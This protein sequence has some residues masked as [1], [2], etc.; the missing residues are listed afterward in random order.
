MMP[1]TSGAF[2]YLEFVVQSCVT[3]AASRVSSRRQHAGGS[4]QNARAPLS[5]YSYE[6]TMPA[7]E[8]RGGHSPF[9]F[10]LDFG[11]RKRAF[12]SGNDQF[13]LAA[14]NFSGLAI[15]IDN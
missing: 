3:L 7:Q 6:R 13:F 11:E 4:G 12:P 8:F 2:G 1:A 14:Q 15:E 10:K 9:S 5:T